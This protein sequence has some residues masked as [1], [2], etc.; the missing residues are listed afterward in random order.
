MR[1]KPS[2]RSVPISPM[3]FDTA[4]YMVIAAPMMAPIEKISDSAGPKWRE[5]R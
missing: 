4:A 3:R 5:G 2:A 1:R